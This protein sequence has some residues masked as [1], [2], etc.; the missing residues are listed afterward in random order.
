MMIARFLAT[1]LAAVLSLG[2]E[3]QRGIDSVWFSS[4]F[5]YDYYP[6]RAS[7]FG[8]EVVVENDGYAPI[9]ARVYPWG[10][11]L[12]MRG[13]PIFV[14]VPP[15]TRLS[16]GTVNP[17]DP[18]VPAD[19]SA[20][21]TFQVG[22]PEAK[23]DRN[24]V[25]R[26]PIGA[27][28]FLWFFD[29]SFEI[30]QAFPTEPGKSHDNVHSRYAVDIVMPIGTPIVAARDG[31]VVQVVQHWER[32]GGDLSVYGWKTNLV[33]IMHDDG[34]TAFYYHL[35]KNS[36]VV[37]TG[38]R[39]R[40]GQLIARSGCSGWCEGPHLHFDVRKAQAGSLEYESVPYQFRLHD[41]RM[42][43]PHAGD[44]VVGF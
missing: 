44:E 36:V 34:T 27:S 38:Q 17:R 40:S 11:N 9:Y 24:A 19:F 41:G 32:G 14:T 1:V 21:M 28:K 22:D 8:S 18:H 30:V 43:T 20:R 2:A 6:A 16:V 5:Y 3:A 13:W 31:L 12:D 29:E 35:L 37:K 39:V 26:L 42:Y 7:A 25:Y 33:K 23:P 15:K 10:K 4:S